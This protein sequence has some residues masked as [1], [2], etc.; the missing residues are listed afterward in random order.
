M[1]G[2]SGNLDGFFPNAQR[3]RELTL[4]G[5]DEAQQPARIRAPRPTRMAACGETCMPP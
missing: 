3:L 5:Q 4:L 1:F 2:L